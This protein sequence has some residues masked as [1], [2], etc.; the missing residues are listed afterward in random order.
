[1]K[2]AL[3]E[4]TVLKKLLQREVRSMTNILFLFLCA[5]AVSFAVTAKAPEAQAH[6]TYFTSQNCS[7]CHNDDTSTCAGCHAHGVHSDNTKSDINL[8][9][10]TDKSSYAPGEAMSVTIDGGYRS[11]WVRAILYDQNG[12]EVARS[13]GP[14]GTGS[15]NSFPIVLS[16]NA[17]TTPGT[18]TYTAAWY[19]N[20][21][22]A[23]GAYFGN[24]FPDP[25]NPNHGEERVQTGSFTVEG[26]SSTGAAPG[27][28]RDG[29]WFLDLDGN[30]QWDGQP[31]D[32]KFRFGG[33]AGDIPVAGD[34]N[35]TGSTRVGIYRDGTWFLDHDGNGQWD[36]QPID[37]KFFFGGSTGS[38]IPHTEDIPVTG[39]WDGTGSTRIG[40]YRD[41]TWFL[42]LDGNGQWDGQPTDSKFRFGG[43]AGDIPVTG[44][45]D[46]TGSTRI[47]IYRDGTWFLD[48]DGN[49][50]WDGQPT[51]SKFRFGGLAGDRPLGGTW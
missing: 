32:S 5:V 28:Y 10:S 39:D 19:G 2:L 14:G 47:G 40:I 38:N 18:Y 44:D 24:W 15:G 4:R 48:L 36:G 51:D 46:G 49:G 35:G 12:T 6:G 42:D 26:T 7:I 9:A 31:T 25:T 20:Q 22:D 3:W 23:S 43:L 50:Q 29:T 16:A 33:L 8:S 13:S 11:G 17:P 1:M 34:W 45:W 21:Y 27:I 30:G 37:R 41:G